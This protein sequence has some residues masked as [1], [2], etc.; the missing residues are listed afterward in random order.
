MQTNKKQALNA[1]VDQ[2]KGKIEEWKEIHSTVKGFSFNSKK[3][4]I[5]A[6]ILGAPT[7]SVIDAYKLY[8]HRGQTKKIDELLIKNCVL[9]GDTKI[10]EEDVD[11][12]NA[13]LKAVVNLMEDLEAD[14]KEL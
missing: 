13:V 9:A 6:Y 12:K 7:N 2:N 8:D 4:G 1:I 10:L 3:S 14:E 11:L 5:Q